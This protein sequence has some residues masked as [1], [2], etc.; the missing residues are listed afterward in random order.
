MGFRDVD[1][2]I[3]SGIRA[4]L[5]GADP[6]L[7]KTSNDGNTARLVTRIR[8]LHNLADAQQ[9][10]P[11][12]VAAAARANDL[13]TIYGLGGYQVEIAAALDDQMV[14]RWVLVAKRQRWQRFLAH[15]IARFFGVFSLQ[16]AAQGRI[17][18]FGRHADVVATAWLVDV[19]MEGILRA[20]DDHIAAWKAQ[21]RRTSGQVR[22]ERSSFCG[23]ATVAFSER[24]I[25]LREDRADQARGQAEAFAGVEHDKRGIRWGR[26]RRAT[27]THN[28]AG[29]ETGNRLPIVR[30]M[31]G[32]KAPKQL[33]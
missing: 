11:E 5:K 30:G 31:E 24:L 3:A 15:A 19:T 33:T 1:R 18:F 21:E 6:P 22:S 4:R 26:A 17:H 32:R 7:P 14:D 28:A 23:S 9:G 29:V 8:K 25:A 16:M 13:I 2:W 20:C 12:G 10:E 27:V